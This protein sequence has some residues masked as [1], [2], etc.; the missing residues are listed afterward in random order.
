M[1]VFRAHAATVRK[2][3]SERHAWPIAHV[4]GTHAWRDGNATV[5]FGARAI[6]ANSEAN[7]APIS[8]LLSIVLSGD[9]LSH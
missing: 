2:S 5:C 8:G 6:F 7:R 1:L 4:C 9:G 3:I